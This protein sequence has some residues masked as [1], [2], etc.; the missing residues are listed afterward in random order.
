MV[1]ILCMPP[2]MSGTFFDGESGKGNQTVSEYLM[3]QY[4]LKV[5]KRCTI[6]SHH[7]C[8]I[9]T[10]KVLVFFFVLYHDVF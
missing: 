8:Q 9:Q 7:T 3:R 5:L 6:C 4:G 10:K 2:E 1:N